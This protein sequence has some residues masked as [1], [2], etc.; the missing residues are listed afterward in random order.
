MNW[1][2]TLRASRH[3]VIFTLLAAGVA[4]CGK[5]DSR[6]QAGAPAG[7]TGDAVAGKS[8]AAVQTQPADRDPCSWMTQT[9][10]EAVI[11]PLVRAPFRNRSSEEMKPAA[12]GETCAY[13]VSVDTGRY[14]GT[15]MES[16]VWVEVATHDGTQLTAGLMGVLRSREL[17][18]A[19]RS[20]GDSAVVGPW[21]QAAGLGG[22]VLAARQGD[23]AIV[24]TSF[25]KNRPKEQLGTL[26]VQ[27][28]AR[29]PELPTAAPPVKEG[30]EEEEEPER[31]PC[32]LVTAAQAE[33][34]LGK[35][36]APPYSSRTSTSMASADGGSCSY[37]TAKHHV[38]VLTPTWEGGKLELQ[39]A[40]SATQGASRFLGGSAEVDTLDG[41]WD[42]VAGGPL[43]DAY[44]L[45]GDALV[46]IQYITSS[47]DIAGAV[48]LARI[49]LAKL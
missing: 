5:R 22:A 7:N 11:G 47:T 6:Q 15:N 32:S 45:K 16:G 14:T 9:E 30:R 39:L 2:L 25:G 24:L 29:I 13:V 42:Q 19:G 4:A 33:A 27:I 28:L 43:G 3:F 10:V 31:D 37:R 35:L 49:A 1:N 38:L 23:A 20:L 41:P 36:T 34:V 26:A 17:D 46:S 12:D 44:F 21:D 40:G 8:G 18:V 48:S